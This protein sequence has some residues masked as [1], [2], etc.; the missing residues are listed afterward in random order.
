[1]LFLRV[2]SVTGHRAIEEP[3]VSSG[4]CFLA[5]TLSFDT[6]LCLESSSGPEIDSRRDFKIFA[7]FL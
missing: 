4:S 1:M 2:L 3:R 6:Y 7:F 5:Q